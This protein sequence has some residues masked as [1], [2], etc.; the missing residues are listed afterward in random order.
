MTKNASLCDALSSGS[1][2]YALFML[3]IEKIGSLIRVSIIWIGSMG[4][5]HFVSSVIV[6]SWRGSKM[7][8]SDSPFLRIITELI[9]VFPVVSESVFT[10]AFISKCVKISSKCCTLSCI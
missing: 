4:Q 10:G 1:W 9:K 2:L 7:N 5:L 8:F 6:F 3:A